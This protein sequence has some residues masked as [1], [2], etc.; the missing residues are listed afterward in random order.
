MVYVA[1]GLIGAAV[2]A[3]LVSGHV[4]R[5]LYTLRWYETANRDWS[6]AADWRRAVVAD[7]AKALRVFFRET[8]YGVVYACVMIASFVARPFGAR[9]RF[10]PFD[11]AQPLVVLIH[12]FFSNPTL[13]TV[14]RWRLRLKR[15]TNVVVYGY[16]WSAPVDH[17]HHR[18]LRDFILAARKQ[19]APAKTIIVG[20]SFGGLVGLAYAAECADADEMVALAALGSPFRG[21]RLATLGITETARSLHP[22]HPRFARLIALRPGCPFLSLATRFDQFVLPWTNSDHPAADTRYVDVCGHAGLVFD[23]RVFRELFGWLAPYLSP[24]R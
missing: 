6:P 17:P 20:H 19:G 21:S 10:S 14:I 12:G 8:V 2:A 3:L 11:P 9:R 24:R 16:P 22:D 7:H 5:E 15:V 13:M 18:R 23:G 4:M 1:V